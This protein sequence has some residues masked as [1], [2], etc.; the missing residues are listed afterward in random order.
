M[1]PADA[2]QHPWY[3]MGLIQNT[4]NASKPVGFLVEERLTLIP[5]LRHFRASSR[6]IFIKKR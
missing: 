4:E 2:P 3:R 6:E 1:A 5:Y